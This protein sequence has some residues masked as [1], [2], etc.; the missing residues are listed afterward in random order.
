MLTF[1]IRA[2]WFRETFRYT[3]QGIA[4][5]PLFIVAIRFPSWL[6][7]RPLNTR[8]LAFLGALSY[9]LYLAHQVVIMAL[10]N[11]YPAIDRYA[12]GASAFAIAFVI[13]YAMHVLV[14]KPCARL[15]RRLSGG[16]KAARPTRSP[17]P[18]GMAIGS[19]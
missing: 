18:V 5:T 16:R 4:L 17:E 19:T 7:L 12:L 14:E 1:A 6:P 3:L 13:A 15:R 11:R 10:L 2:S 8:A 9:T